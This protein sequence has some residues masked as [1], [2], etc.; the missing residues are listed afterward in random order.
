MSCGRNESNYNQ[1]GNYYGWRFENGTLLFCDHAVVCEAT[2][3]ADADIAGKG[4]GTI[5]LYF[6]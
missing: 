3:A 4:V 5:P 2:F 1:T 6:I